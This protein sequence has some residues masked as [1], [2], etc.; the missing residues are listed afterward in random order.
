[1]QLVVLAVNWLRKSASLLRDLCRDHPSV[2][3]FLRSCRVAV[4]DE[5]QQG[6]A[7]P[8]LPPT[9]A[10]AVFKSALVTRNKPAPARAAV[11][12]WHALLS[13]QFHHR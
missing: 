11:L 8:F 13:N 4:S 5:A 6:Q 7:P 12:P 10:S 1:M 2:R 3:H 9:S